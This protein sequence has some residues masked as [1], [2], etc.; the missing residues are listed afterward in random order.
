MEHLFNKQKVKTTIA[1]PLGMNPCSLLQAVYKGNALARA[2]I[3]VLPIPW[4]NAGEQI[5]NF[6]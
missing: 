3:P 6:G 2:I 4:L 1:L 5:D